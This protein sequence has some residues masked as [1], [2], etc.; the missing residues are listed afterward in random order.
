LFARFH[1]LLTTLLVAVVVV[2]GVV[3]IDDLGLQA[4]TESVEKIYLN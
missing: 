2:D 1:V 4:R 3:V